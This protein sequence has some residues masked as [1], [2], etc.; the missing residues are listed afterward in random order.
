MRRN[1]RRQGNVPQRFKQA[2]IKPLKIYAQLI[3]DSAGRTLACAS[4]LEL[5]NKKKKTAIAFEVGK[6]LAAKALAL[7]IEQVVF[8]RGGYAYHGRVKSLADGAREGGLKF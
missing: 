7:K 8:D 4:T 2:E 3:D 5:K 6:Q 1:Q